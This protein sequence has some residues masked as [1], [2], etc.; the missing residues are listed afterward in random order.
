MG[1]RPDRDLV[2]ARRT[3]RRWSWVVYLMSLAVDVA[4]FRAGHPMIGW[5]I[6]MAAWGGSLIVRDRLK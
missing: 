3:Y 5:F 4:L 6:F 2:A 1:D